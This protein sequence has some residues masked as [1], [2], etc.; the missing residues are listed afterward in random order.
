VVGSSTSASPSMNHQ[1][2]HLLPP[3]EDNNYGYSDP[4]RTPSPTFNNEEGHFRRGPSTPGVR[5]S[6]MLMGKPGGPPPPPGPPRTY[7]I[8]VSVYR[9]K[10]RYST[11]TTT[12]TS[13]FDSSICSAGITFT[14]VFFSLTT[15]SCWSEPACSTK[16]INDKY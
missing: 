10:L 15:T 16:G 14:A 8:P 11:R 4:H 1:Q 6:R 3:S 9:H 7:F 13:S 5:I 2:Q 12:I